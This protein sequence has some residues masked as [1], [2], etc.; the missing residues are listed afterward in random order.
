VS[1]EV[2]AAVVVGFGV[3]GYAMALN[4]AIDRLV[5]A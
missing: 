3:A 2:A 5:A 1:V 4:A